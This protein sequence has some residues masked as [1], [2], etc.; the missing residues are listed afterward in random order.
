M[1]KS[2][3]IKVNAGIPERVLI[4]SQLWNVSPLSHGKPVCTIIHNMGIVIIL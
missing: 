3:Q 4:L 1:E 2:E